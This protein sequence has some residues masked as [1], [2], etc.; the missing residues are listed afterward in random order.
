[1]RTKK[2]S[3][4]RREAGR[5][6]AEARWGGRDG[7]ATACLRVYPADAEEIKK[8]AKASGRLPADEVAA[9]L[10]RSARNLV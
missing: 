7:R 4:V 5:K 8:R 3:K 9:L 10:A 6:G 1:M 2:L